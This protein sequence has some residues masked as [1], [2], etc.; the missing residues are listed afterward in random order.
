MY[1]ILR[2]ILLHKKGT[3]LCFDFYCDTFSDSVMLFFSGWV[4]VRNSNKQLTWWMLNSA[5][6]SQCG[7]SS[8]P[9]TKGSLSTCVSLQRC[10]EWCSLPE[11]KS[12]MER[13]G[14]FC[15]SF[16]CGKFITESAIMLYYGYQ[17]GVPPPL[18]SLFSL[19]SLS[20]WSLACSQRVKREHW[21][22][23]RKVE[24][25]SMTLSLLQ[26]ESIVS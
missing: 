21:R 13:L 23:W 17:S 19:P 14:L 11:R 8:G 18:P 20:V 16:N 22:L 9:H 2:K 6:K 7:D 12:K 26:S 3:S 15:V 5:W 1:L 10:G 24:A 25:S 4:H